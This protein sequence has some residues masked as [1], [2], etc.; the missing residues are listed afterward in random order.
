MAAD[1]LLPPATDVVNELF[2][3]TTSNL[4]DQMR[5]VGI[6]KRAHHSRT[7]SVLQLAANSTA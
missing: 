5:D 3:V 7:S 4:R 6:P 1:K 2:I